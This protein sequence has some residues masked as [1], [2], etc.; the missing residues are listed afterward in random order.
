M[1]AIVLI[2]LALF[3][4]AAI[5]QQSGQSSS[6][7]EPQSFTKVT[8]VGDDSLRSFFMFS[9]SGHDYTIRADGFGESTFEKARA[10]NFNLK[11]DQRH[12]EQVYFLEYESDLLLLY[13]LSDAQLVRGY[14]IRLN[15]TTLKPL[16]QVAVRDVDLETA[17]VEKGQ[18]MLKNAAA[19]IKIDLRTGN[20]VEN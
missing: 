11:V 4:S 1:K 8:R 10:R 13:Q 3:A 2:S 17:V 9:V 15:Q 20:V 18:V 16:W 19:P 14:L 7:K 12:V 6:D 5:A